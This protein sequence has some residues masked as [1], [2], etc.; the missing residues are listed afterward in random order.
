MAKFL[1][2]EAELSQ[3]RVVEIEEKGKNTRIKNCFRFATPQG[4]VEDGQIRDTQ[5][6]GGILRS[7]LSARK[8]KT[9][10][11][12]FV[13][14]STRIA[15]RE[16]RLPLVKKNRIQSI[17]EAN[18]TDYFP[19][20]VT[21]Y[22]LS[23]SVIDVEEKDG[24][25]KQYHLMVYAAPRALSAAYRELAEAAGLNMIGLTYTGDS[26]YS[27]VKE[28]FHAGVNVLIKIEER[29]TGISI[30]KDGEIALQRNLNYGVDSAAETVRMFPV[31]GTNLS[32]ERAMDI[33]CSRKCV[34]K[35]FDLAPDEY[36]PEDTDD[37]VREARREITESLR[38]LVG[39]VSRIM[40]YYVSRNTDTV[41]EE[42]MV[43]GLG[44][45][46]KG[47]A[48]LLTQELGQRAEILEDL[49]HFIMPRVDVDG[50]L[51]T[52]VGVIASMKSGMNLTEKVAK[53]GKEQ[54]DTISGAVLVCVV[55]ALAGGVLCASSIGMRMYQEN[56]QKKLNQ[57]IAQEQEIETI[58][59]G[60]QDSKLKYEQ[61]LTMYEY[62]NTPNEALVEFINEMEKKMPSAIVVETFSSTGTEV[63]FSMK[64]G[65]KSEAAET[66]IQLR[67]F[68][69]LSDVTT[70]GIDE[71]EDGTVSMTVTCT[72][73]EPAP[74]DSK[75]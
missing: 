58:Y 48:E 22:I 75:N 9:K 26:V 49:P 10:K 35:S 15:S 63:N 17:L 67:S 8:I 60:Y 25:E 64:V 1:S 43:C 39:N 24:G 20:D 41:F 11:V 59:N 5:T 29:T 47:L 72:Y 33:L 13:T 74:L 50:G 4:A 56:E 19:I 30:V 27:A 12:C 44:A 55:G 18:V 42:I 37:F 34:R 65:S 57:R 62:T 68:E 6:L 21:K 73:A 46:V 61:F 40:D 7:E 28:E 70:T 66:I 52:Y 38:Y 54:K 2:I 36:E 23:Y 69:S 53:K 31:F 71:G 14:S 45:E 32:A 51:A 3:I 16:V